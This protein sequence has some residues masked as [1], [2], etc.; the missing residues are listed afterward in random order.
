MNDKD[1]AQQRIETLRIEI[2]RHNRLYYIDATPEITDREY[3]QLLKS[4]EELER[5][6]PE[7]SSP[8]SPTQRVGGAPL[9]NFKNVRH[10][11]PMMSLSNTYSK[12]ELVEFDRRI[13][14]LIPEETFQYILEPKIDGVAISLRYE[15][16]KLVHAV[17]RGDGATGDDVTSN[18]RTI[19]SIP[20][21]LSDMMPPAVLEVRGEIYMDIAGFANLNE[22]RQEAGQEPFA[23][24]RNACAGSL[25]QLDPREVAKRPLD[26]I[27]YATGELNGI[28]FETHE[29]MLLSLKNYGLRITPNYWISPKIEDILDQLDVL[30]S[31]RHEFPFEMDGGVI[32]V[33]DRRLYEDL[34]S[35]AKSPRWAVAYKYEPEQAETTLHA[36]S[37]QVGRTGVLTPVA[38]LDPVS[39]AGTTVK[40]ATLHNEDEIRRKGIKIGDKVIIEKAG[41][42]IP[43]VVK[44][45]TEKRNGAEIDFSM[46][47]SCP[48]CGSEVEKREGEVAL[49]CINL[50][51][52]AQVKN[53]IAHYASRGA[54]D[55]NG[56]GESLV[57]QL[58]DSGLVKNPA[59][60]YSL[61]KVEVLGL[62]RMGEK[63]ADKLIK[64]IAESKQRPF[65]KVLFGLGI[66]HVGKGAAL[67]LSKQFKTIDALITADIQKLET[68]RDIGPIVGKTV[69]EYFQEPETRRVIDALQAEGVNFEQED[70]GTTN[71][72]EGLTFVLTG[73]LKTMTRDEGGDKIRARGGK[74]S[75]S[76]SK[77]T[78]YL[79]AGES[80]GSKLA[81]AETLGVTILNEE[82]F[83]ALLGSE[84]VRQDKQSGQLGFGF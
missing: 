81:K 20:L 61:K 9:E 75:S 35:T 29:Q 74:V 72:L 69:V 40:R 14:K 21:R 28:S 8:T 30:E 44:V 11:V 70:T 38:E 62:E 7:F 57:E 63:S 80:A 41:E 78:S 13:Q 64:G 46:P 68:I 18:V 65:E 36:I 16:G 49:R 25:K 53:W 26:A 2:E 12:E 15:N 48:V 73:S 55:I 50:Q 59:E 1:P 42:I 76:I 39:L 54:M 47:S 60:L 22:N 71:E 37:I 10:A 83:I 3:D 67:I 17:T 77:K 5:Q 31:M 19:Q 79:V 82:Q 58:V 24:P 27:F 6:F 45:V 66:R 23:N 84:D 43:A 51:C 4:L 32:K 34:G 33:N 56:L 52:P